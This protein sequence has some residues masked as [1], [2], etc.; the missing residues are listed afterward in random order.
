LKKASET[1]GGI[2]ANEIIQAE[3][4]VEAARAGARWHL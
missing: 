1:P 4:V 2:A 3:K